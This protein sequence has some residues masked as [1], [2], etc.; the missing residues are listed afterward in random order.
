MELADQTSSEIAHRSGQRL[1]LIGGRNFKA[2][3]LEHLGVGWLSPDEHE[4]KY[5]TDQATAEP[6]RSRTKGPQR[7]NMLF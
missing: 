6:N 2:L 1:D 7:I 4:E 3:L 5:Y